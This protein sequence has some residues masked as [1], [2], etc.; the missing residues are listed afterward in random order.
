MHLIGKPL[1]INSMRFCVDALALRLDHLHIS[2]HSFRIRAATE[3]ATLGLY[4]AVIK[5]IGGWKSKYYGLYTRPPN[6][7]I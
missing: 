5:Q 4:E 1:T 3:A 7:L 2:S 6:S